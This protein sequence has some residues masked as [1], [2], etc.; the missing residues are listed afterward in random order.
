M[1]FENT[2][3]KIIEKEC[4]DYFL[5]IADLSLA[6]N[7]ILKQYE[8]FFDEYPRAISIGITLPYTATRKTVDKNTKV[9]N[10]TNQQLNAITVSLSK[11]LQRNGYKTLSI[12][13]TEKVDDNNFISLHKLAANVA[14][15]GK[16][17]KNG[18]LITPEA[19]SGVNWGTILTDA[20]LEAANQ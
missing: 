5:G 18:L 1:E 14:N 11:L 17:E 7:D 15:L 3:R 12:P 10:E 16:I 13:K 6:E 9:Y 19:G 20:P 8:S 4:E 2:I